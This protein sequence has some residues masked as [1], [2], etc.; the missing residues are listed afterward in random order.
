MLRNYWYWLK[1]SKYVLFLFD[2]TKILPLKGK[3]KILFF[4]KLIDI[5]LSATKKITRSR[6]YLIDQ[7]AHLYWHTSYL[8]RMLTPGLYIHHFFHLYAD[9]VSIF[10]SCSS[11]LQIFSKI[12]L[13]CL[14]APLRFTL[15]YTGVCRPRSP[16]S[17]H[18]LF[19]ISVT[20]DPQPLELSLQLHL[21]NVR[22]MTANA[23]K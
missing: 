22:F 21:E 8:R 7:F 17:L 2:I 10:Q 14:I 9:A 18:I 3:P 6:W 16:G 11:L 5:S 15:Y 20:S 4:G 23:Q 1:S 13:S 12:C 19:C